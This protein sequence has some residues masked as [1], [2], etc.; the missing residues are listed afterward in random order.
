[1]KTAL[2]WLYGKEDLSQREGC[3]SPCPACRGPHEGASC[4]GTR[5]KVACIRVEG[6]RT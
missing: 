2:K 5:A 3:T 4:R 1:L 6:R